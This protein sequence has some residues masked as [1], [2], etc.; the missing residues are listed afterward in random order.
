MAPTKQWQLLWAWLD[1]VLNDWLK[2]AP[3]G[4]RATRFATLT[5][6]NSKI[7]NLRSSSKANGP[8]TVLPFFNSHP[9]SLQ[10]LG[11]KIRLFA[12]FFGLL[13][14]LSTF[15]RVLPGSDTCEPYQ[16]DALN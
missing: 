4:L 3:R 13:S 1:E 2:V 6:P 7:A 16:H 11:F 8:A 15:D 14:R 12:S 9:P 5:E 10:A